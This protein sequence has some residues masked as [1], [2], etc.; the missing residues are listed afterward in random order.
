M[1]TE[2]P[3]SGTVV[4]VTSS[5]PLTLPD[6]AVMVVVPTASG[7]ALPVTLLM[8]TIP[9]GVA[10]QVNDGCGSSA[11]LLRNAVAVNCD[12]NPSVSVALPETV[13]RSSVGGGAL[14]RC[15]GDALLRGTT[16]AVAKSADEL[17]LHVHPAFERCTDVVL[18]LGPA[19]AGVQFAL[20]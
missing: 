14:Q 15:T 1:T 6:V 19:A 4:T 17:P 20:P 5:V 12:G 11:T 3:R 9:A 10:V 13:M 18:L 7:V 16:G 2:P 8:S